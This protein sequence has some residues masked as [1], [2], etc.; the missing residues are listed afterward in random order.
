MEYIENVP[1]LPGV[2]TYPWKFTPK[3][4]TRMLAGVGR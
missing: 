2:F 4:Q 3:T 1:L